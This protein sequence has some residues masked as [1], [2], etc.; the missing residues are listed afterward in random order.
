MKL[1][2]S[3]ITRGQFLKGCLASLGALFAMQSASPL[4]RFLMPPEAEMGPSE[5]KLSMGELNLE[6]N[7][8]KIIPFGK[9]PALL[10]K[11][12]KGEWIC[13]S[14]V[15]THFECTVHYDPATRE[16]VCPC[17]HGFFDIYGKNIKGPPPGPLKAYEVQE[18]PDG[19][20]I[21]KKAKVK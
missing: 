11:T 2:E 4:A 14:A 20:L 16:I 8:G 5:I 10:I 15:C 7:S 6:P 9:K 21:T 13:L 3:L 17:H 19:L 12:D 1:K 18:V